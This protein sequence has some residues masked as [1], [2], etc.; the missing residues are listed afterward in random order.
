MENSVHTV[1]KIQ[2]E[3]LLEHSKPCGVSNLGGLTRVVIGLE[4]LIAPQRF[5]WELFFCILGEAV[6][7]F[8]SNYEISGIDEEDIPQ[9]DI[10]VQ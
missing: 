8:P 1:E 7:L 9:A 6:A 4:L 5:G 3:S 10:S 2:P